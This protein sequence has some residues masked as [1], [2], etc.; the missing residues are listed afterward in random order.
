MFFHNK[1]LFKKFIF[2]NFNVL[3][4]W[5]YNEFAEFKGHLC[6]RKRKTNRIQF[7]IS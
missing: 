4:G 2:G 5:V 1:F 6:E 3:I 7:V